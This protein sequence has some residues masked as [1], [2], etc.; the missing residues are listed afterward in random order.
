[1]MRCGF[2]RLAERVRAVIADPPQWSPFFVPLTTRG[3][4]EDFV[5][6]KTDLFVVQVT[7]FT[8]QLLRLDPMILI[9]SLF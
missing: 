5:V 8:L 7:G 6:G 1:M 3:S 2:D 4:T 9:L